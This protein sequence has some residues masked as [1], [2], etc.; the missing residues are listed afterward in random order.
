MHARPPAVLVESM[1][2]HSD[3]QAG[4]HRLLAA[5]PRKIALCGFHQQSPQPLSLGVGMHEQIVNVRLAARPRFTGIQV[6]ATVHGRRNAEHKA[7][8]YAVYV[9]DETLA[10]R[11]EPRFGTGTK[12]RG[13]ARLER[14]VVYRFDSRPVAGRALSHGGMSRH[15]SGACS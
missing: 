7:L 13:V 15:R 5:L 2:I 8:H 1:R 12:Q 10:A 4:Q 11:V 14:G 3:F 6:R 9:G